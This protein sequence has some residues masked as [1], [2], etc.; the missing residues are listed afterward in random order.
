MQYRTKFCLWIGTEFSSTISPKSWSLSNNGSVNWV[1]TLPKIFFL[2]IPDWRRNLL[3]RR[4]KPI[5][6][7]FQLK[8]QLVFDIKKRNLNKFNSYKYKKNGSDWALALRRL[9]YSNID[10][11]K[12]IWLLLAKKLISYMHIIMNILL[13]WGKYR[14]FSQT[15]NDIVM[16]LVLFYMYTLIT[17]TWTV[18]GEGI[19]HIYYAINIRYCPTSIYSLDSSWPEFKF[20]SIV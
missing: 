17:M 20:L 5:A 7:L 15:H 18:I 8:C 3:H 19:Y 13:K 12:S 4:K 6:R 1:M 2:Q 9:W 10:L 11:L 14:S 16:V